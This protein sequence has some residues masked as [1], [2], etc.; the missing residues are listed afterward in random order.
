ME[1]PWILWSCKPVH[2][3]VTNEWHHK[4]LCGCL[5]FSCPT[6]SSKQC[7]PPH[8][9]NVFCG[10]WSHITYTDDRYCTHQCQNKWY[11]KSNKTWKECLNT[12]SWICSI[13]LNRS[14]EN[15]MNMREKKG[16]FF[17]VILTSVRTWGRLRSWIFPPS[18]HWMSYSSCPLG[19]IS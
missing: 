11:K 19:S 6:K 12:E 18:V 13:H 15:A 9:L 17:S 5:C 3:A 7:W 4:E 8:T 14:V 16:C 10:F 2:G 1:L